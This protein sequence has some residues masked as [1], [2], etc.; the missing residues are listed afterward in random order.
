[1]I[2][3]ILTTFQDENGSRHWRVRRVGRF[4]D[5]PLPVSLVWGDNYRL[6]VRSQA[7]DVCK[8]DARSIKADRYVVVEEETLSL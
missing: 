2:K 4:W 1:M 3:Y 6:E 8:Q 5:T 7:I